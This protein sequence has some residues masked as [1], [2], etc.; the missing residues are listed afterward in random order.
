L[1]RLLAPI[2]SFTAEEAWST[3]NKGEASVFEQMWYEFG[4]PDDAQVLRQRWKQLRALRSDV[5]KQLEALRAAGSIGSSLAAEVDLHA[6]GDSGAFLRSFGNDLRFVFITSQAVVHDSGEDG[7]ATALPDVKL[8]LKP[9]PHRKC[10]R[11]WHYRADV[12]QDPAQ[13]ELCARC[14]SNLCGAGEQRQHA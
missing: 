6:S 10:E 3:L 8:T 12:G 9:S 11:C 7:I 2:V 4:F 14:I 1:T 5:Q 13:P